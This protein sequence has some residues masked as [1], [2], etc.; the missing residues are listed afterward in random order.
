MSIYESN[1]NNYQRPLDGFQT[2]AIERIIAESSPERVLEVGCAT[3]KLLS[4]FE[5]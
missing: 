1:R 2:A 4:R 3:G 5:E